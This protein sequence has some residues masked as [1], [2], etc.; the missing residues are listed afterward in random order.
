MKYFLMSFLLFLFST[1]Q[2]QSLIDSIGS[3]DFMIQE[4][5][6]EKL[7]DLAVSNNR[8]KIAEKGME[9]SK[10]EIKRSQAD[11]LNIVS[12]SYN[13][14]LFNLNN[15]FKSQ[16]SQF[17][18]KYNGGVSIPLGFFFTRMSENK[19]A[20]GNY[21]RA[22]AIRDQE[23]VEVKRL[24]KIQCQ[25]YQSNLYLLSLQES[26]LQDE[27]ILL[28]NVSNLFDN[29]QADLQA[30]TD[31]TRRYNL[32]LA[33][34][35]TLIKEVNSSK[36]ELEALLGMKLSEALRKIRVTRF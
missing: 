7:A 1:V 29:N 25:T 30:F 12:G 2:S 32:E 19:I 9:V 26:L 31:A 36:F 8:V 17:W 34:K 24:I 4:T 28:D 21:E 16:A 6:A 5:I 22:I 33:K 13:H 35:I 27:K 18:P 15:P 3:T 23:V 10:S 14:V 11:W 20:K